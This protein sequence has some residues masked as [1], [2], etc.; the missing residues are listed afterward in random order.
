MSGT[1]FPQWPSPEEI[2]R[3][4]NPTG[5]KQTPTPWKAQDDTGPDRFFITDRFGNR[6]A[7]FDRAED[8]DF[9][10]WWSNTHGGVI[11]I[12]RQY[13]DAFGFAAM[14]ADNVGLKDFAANQR[15]IAEAWEQF[16]TTMGRSARQQNEIDK[17]K[18]K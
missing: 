6:V 11:A 2:E 12:L 17:L 7:L 5:G 10:L 14:G 15:E 4:M 16:F 18:P 8:R 9:A 3:L 13:K 1:R